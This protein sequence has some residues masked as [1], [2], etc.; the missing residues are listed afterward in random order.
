MPEATRSGMA[1]N[2]MC[3]G[4]DE[5]KGAIGSSSRVSVPMVLDAPTVSTHGALP[6][7][8]MPPHCNWPALFFPWLPAATTTVMPVSVTAFAARVKGSVQYDSY[9]PAPTD[10][11]TTRIL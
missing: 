1:Q 6:G 2:S 7:A 8:V 5:L 10:R 4:P 9:T 3:V 11:F